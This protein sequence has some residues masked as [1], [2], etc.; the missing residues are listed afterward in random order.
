MAIFQPPKRLANHGA[1]ATWLKY[2][3]AWATSE[4]VFINGWK[5]EH[6]AD[7]KYFTPPSSVQN[8]N[9]IV[10][11]SP[12]KEL[13]PKV[14][15]PANTLVSISPGNALVTTGL[16][17]LVSAVTVKA[18]SGVWCA[19]QNV[20]AQ[21][22]AG[23]NVPALPLPGSNI[24]TPAVP[25]GTPLRGDADGV[26]VFWMPFELYNICANQP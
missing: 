13:D 1:Q 14:F 3:V 12:Y 5:F 21:V 17:D 15:V 11:Q 23:Y 7:G 10:W 19:V 8:K 26:S 2:L 20:P 4:R 6:R 24:T 18:P 9:G 16:V 25:S 22:T